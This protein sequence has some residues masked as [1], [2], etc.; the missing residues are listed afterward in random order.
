MREARVRAPSHEAVDILRH[1]DV[2]DLHLD[3]FLW[4]RLF[5]Y[6]LT[7][8]HGTG[9]FD[10]RLLG[11]ADV[12]RCLDAGITGAYWII[13]T[14]PLRSASGRRAALFANLEALQARL[15]SHP[16]VQLVSTASEYRAARSAN[17][18]AAF[19]GLQGGNALDASLDD[20]DSTALSMISLITLVHMTRSRIGAPAL[21]K[22]LTRGD[23]KL[24]PFGHDYVRKLNQRRVLVDLAHI[25]REGFWNALEAHDRAL[26]LTVSHTGCDAVFSH[27]R[28]LDDAQLR[29]VAST[30][31]VVGIMFHSDYLTASRRSASLEH[32][33]DH[34]MHALRIAG[35]DHVALG[36]DFDGF[37]IPPRDFKTV[38]Q[39]P[40]LVDALLRRGVAHEVLQKVLGGNFVRVLSALRP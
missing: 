20:F 19:I 3:T 40:L 33:A 24:T 39:L 18:H 36:S 30:G 26:P 29:A 4:Q 28:N 23:Q 12:P 7:R 34:I 8:R 11:Q 38:E 37:I 35:P 31:G 21:P 14:N 27:F 10:A 6:D 22:L 15:A 32:V 13:T 17:K 25:S 5:G 16:R 9:P 1:A 2:I